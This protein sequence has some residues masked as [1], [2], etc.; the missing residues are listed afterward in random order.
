[1]A[2]TQFRIENRKA[3]RLAECQ[4]VPR[5]MVIAGA[6][7]VGKSTLLYSIRQK[8][9][10][11]VHMAGKVL[12]VPPHRGWRKQQ[13]RAMHLWT[14]PR[15]FSDFLASD[16]VSG[17]EG[18]RFWG[19]R[20]APDSVDETQGTIK[21]V[22]SQ[23]ETRR[24][25]AIT[26][27]VDKNKGQFPT[28]PV[29]DPYKPLRELIDY[30]LPHLSFVQVSLKHRDNVQ[31][32]WKRTDLADAGGLQE[33]DIDELSSGEK[34][35]ISLFLPFL[36]EQ[37]N[38]ILT[39]LEGGT[40]LSAV[41][42]DL[43]ILIDEPELHLHPALQAK[44]LDY[45]R[46]VVTT[47][48]TQFII[49]THSPVLINEARVEELYMLL[50][51]EPVVGFNQLVRAT[52]D[53]DRYEALR[54]VCG[55]ISFITQGK[56]TLLIEGRN[57]VELSKE[58]SDRRIIELICPDFQRC[59]IIPVGKKQRILE[60][61][62]ILSTPESQDAIGIRVF[63]VTDSDR[64][65]KNLDIGIDRI[66]N[67]PSCMIENFLLEPVAINSILEAHREKTGLSDP[68][69]IEVAL[70]AIA[71]NMRQAEIELRVAAKL[72][73]FRWHPSGS[74]TQ[75][76]KEKLEEAVG[77]L[78]G[79]FADEL[80]LKNIFSEAT[81]EVDKILSEKKE[82]QYF[83]GKNILKE[84]Y[85]K[86]VSGKGVDFGYVSFCYA[87]AGELAKIPDVQAEFRTLLGHALHF[88]P[89]RLLNQL[90]EINRM[91]KDLKTWPTKESLARILEKAI[92]LA[93]SAITE[94][95]QWRNPEASRKELK[96]LCIQ[97]IQDIRQNAS[98]LPPETAGTL[99]KA[100]E[101]L[102]RFALEIGVSTPI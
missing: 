14:N 80:A 94:R 64:P 63:G 93:Q 99:I 42:Q 50:P 59:I 10:G 73:P 6:N 32:L 74:S 54:L 1:M 48:A 36:E 77:K 15:W 65:N 46:K 61:C 45:F 12:Y 67:W 29:P 16:Q 101:N 21:W 83:H 98:I 2:L 26:A 82:L 44:L 60:I 69:A 4:S 79:R 25:D 9:G 102:H 84:F 66:F 43:I 13:I 41:S 33:F 72:E 40:P 97:V 58:P 95:K 7:G 75:E 31:C 24:R 96:G 18:L 52:E 49:A 86:H 85:K 35:I 53:I 38:Q 3:L 51:T 88:V 20:R 89:L 30:L 62:K 8:E 23:I 22:L 28:G 90:T 5:I 87:I 39:E 81:E 55:D 71:R 17:I 76:L 57:P 47:T 27:V 91:V 68:Q 56:P 37:M 11:H 34:E 100:A 78:V 70:R 92:T 19:E